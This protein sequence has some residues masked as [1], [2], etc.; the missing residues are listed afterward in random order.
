[1][2]KLERVLRER[3]FFKVRMQGAPPP[4]GWAL[5]YVSGIDDPEIKP[6]FW[7]S[8]W[9]VS[10]ERQTGNFNFDRELDLHFAE[11]SIAKDIS[12]ALRNAVGVK[13]AVVKIG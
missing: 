4:S 12:D 8:E 5:R 7:L 10:A 3:P 13:T 1:M 11:E 2:A 9:S 6:G